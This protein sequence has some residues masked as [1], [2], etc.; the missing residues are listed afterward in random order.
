GKAPARQGVERTENLDPKEATLA[1]QKR[2]RK[3]DLSFYWER[4]MLSVE[5]SFDLSLGLVNSRVITN[6]ERP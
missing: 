5:I 2:P 1:K 3:W 6:R 4:P